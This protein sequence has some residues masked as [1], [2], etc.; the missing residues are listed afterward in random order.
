MQSNTASTGS[1]G[2][3]VLLFP[4]QQPAREWLSPG[5]GGSADS[6][7]SLMARSACTNPVC[8]VTK[9]SS[10]LHAGAVQA[11]GHGK[12]HVDPAKAIKHRLRGGD[13]AEDDEMW[14]ESYVLVS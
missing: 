14:T 10:A 5:L 11:V 4:R 6:R 8:D 12:T 13:K 1:A 2:V 3:A 7:A 9:L